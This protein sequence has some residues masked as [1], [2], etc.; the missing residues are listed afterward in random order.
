MPHI[1]KAYSLKLTHLCN[2][3]R[4]FTVISSGS[5]RIIETDTKTKY[6]LT[7]VKGLVPHACKDVQADVLN[8]MSTNP[9][10]AI[11]SG[12]KTFYINREL[13]TRLMNENIYELPAIDINACY[14][15]ILH[16]KGILSD[17]TYY[18]Y[19]NKKTERLIAVGN[20]YKTVRVVQYISGEIVGRPHVSRYDWE[21]VW[22]YVVSETWQLFEKINMAVGGNIVMFKTDCFYVLPCNVNQ[23]IELIE[24]YGYT[25][26]SEI[27]TIIRS[28]KQYL[29]INNPQ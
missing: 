15:N 25:C 11:V 1:N 13:H 6:C 23:V 22:R 9:I 14:W 17:K 24:L 27:K 21:W 16:N 18:K 2:R 28:K 7:N 5:I 29:N 20:L 19:L 3:K 26:K 8:Y 10:P 4:D 12:S